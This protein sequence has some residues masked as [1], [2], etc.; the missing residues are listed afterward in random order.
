ML[1]DTA[2]DLVNS[3]VL[4]RCLVMFTHVRGHGKE[5]PVYCKTEKCTATGQGP[6]DYP[7]VNKSPLTIRLLYD[8]YLIF[9]LKD[10][11]QCISLW[12]YTILFYIQ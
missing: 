5:Y 9:T 1:L 2:R 10:Y 6:N 11:L 3:A 7:I 12:F 8:L 4:L